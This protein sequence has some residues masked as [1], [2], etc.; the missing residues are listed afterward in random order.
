[1]LGVV[2]PSKDMLPHFLVLNY[3]S[4]IHDVL[5][6]NAI[7][8]LIH[9][10]YFVGSLT[11]VLWFKVVFR[12]YVIW[13]R[14]EVS[15]SN[16]EWVVWWTPVTRKQ[17]QS[18]IKTRRMYFENRKAVFFCYWFPTVYHFVNFP[19][20]LCW[21]LLSKLILYNIYK[22]DISTYLHLI[23]DSYWKWTYCSV[24]KFSS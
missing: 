12:M 14:V 13:F 6:W 20:T 4:I 19:M 22:V 18:K 8:S 2:Q 3:D 7:F 17:K 9:T 23:I 16:V 21:S 15:G 10:L 1:M 24:P 5:R 11:K